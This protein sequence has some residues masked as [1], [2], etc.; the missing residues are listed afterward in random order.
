M[1]EKEACFRNIHSSSGTSYREFRTIVDSGRFPS[2]YETA[3]AEVTDDKVICVNQVTGEKIELEADTV[4]LAVGMK[5]LTAKAEELR[6]SAP[7]TS[8]R[9]VGDVKKL[10]TIGT[11][12]NQAFQAALHI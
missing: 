11:A 5:P 8:V 2:Y 6:R 4:L 3:L 9:L 10:G 12:V 7:E 1:Q